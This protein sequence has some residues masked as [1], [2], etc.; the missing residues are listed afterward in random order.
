MRDGS[1]HDGVDVMM[2]R[3]CA[4]ATSAGKSLNATRIDQSATRA[5][6]RLTQRAAQALTNGYP[7]GFVIEKKTAC[8]YG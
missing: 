8:R 1:P 6:V 4:G 5:L 3:L 7:N 2:A